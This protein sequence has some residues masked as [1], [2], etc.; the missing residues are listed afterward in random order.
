MTFPFFV[1]WVVH[2]DEE[3]LHLWLLALFDKP[4]M[5]RL[6]D[7]GQVFFLFYIV[8]SY[9]CVGCVVGLQGF[10]PVYEREASDGTVRPVQAFDVSV[11][12]D[13]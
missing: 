2:V 11:R 13:A 6:V 4:L 8:A 10:S 12:P 7:T 3:P 5:C 9:M 1:T